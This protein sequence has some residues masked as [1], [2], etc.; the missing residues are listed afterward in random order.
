MALAHLLR[1]SGAPHVVVLAHSQGSVIAADALCDLARAYTGERAGALAQPATA[2]SLAPLAAHLRE[3]G[4]R[5]TLV[6]VGSPLSSLYRSFF[7]VTIGREFIELCRSEPQRFAW[8]NVCRAADYIGSRIVLA[9]V[10]NYLL[11]T[12]GD[13]TG[14]WRD[15]VLLQWLSRY[16]AGQGV[17]QAAAFDGSAALVP[18]G[19]VRGPAERA[20]GAVATG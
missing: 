19:G 7:G 8:V 12:P 18:L 20:G 1:G 16:A 11:A 17:A 2:T 14:Y 10:R 9:G 4:Q 13:H 5:I 6:T 3:S 15:P